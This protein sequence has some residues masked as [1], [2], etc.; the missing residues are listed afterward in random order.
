MSDSSFT[1]LLQVAYF[2]EYRASSTMANTALIL[3]V[4]PWYEPEHL[5]AQIAEGFTVPFLFFG[6]KFPKELA[7]E[8]FWVEVSG[9]KAGQTFSI[10]SL[11]SLSDEER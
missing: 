6:E 1:A 10:A 5:N 11:E 3:I 4:Q 8:R 7:E 2:P 9:P